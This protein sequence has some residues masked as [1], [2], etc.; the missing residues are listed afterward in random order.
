M[1]LREKNK[2]KNKKAMA[3][4]SAVPSCQSFVVQEII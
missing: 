3:V 4:L 2:N 1:E